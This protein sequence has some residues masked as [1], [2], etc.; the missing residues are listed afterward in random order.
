MLRTIQLGAVPVAGAIVLFGWALTTGHVPP[1]RSSLA[2]PSLFPVIAA[3]SRPATPVL[4]RGGTLTFTGRH[5][6]HAGSIA[7]LARWGSGRWKT[8]ASLYG[9]R[10]AYSVR[11]PLD[12]SGVL[13]L[14]M[15]YPDGSVGV[16]TYRVK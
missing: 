16:K 12:R 5:T 10:P 3:A 9:L 11:V 1:G 2:G 15:R 4:R 13:Q 14:K 8:L 7:I 6:P